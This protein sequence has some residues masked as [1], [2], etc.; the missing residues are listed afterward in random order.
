M[1]KRRQPQNAKKAAAGR[2]HALA[3]TEM[4]RYPTEAR[5]PAD[6]AT[7][8]PIKAVDAETRRLIDEAIARRRA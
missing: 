4:L 5:A 3:R 2:V 7:S 6:G 8:H 1:G